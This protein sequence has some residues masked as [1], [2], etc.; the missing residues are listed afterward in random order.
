MIL[1]DHT[2]RSAI[3]S[4]RI[5]VDPIPHSDQIQPASLDL[6]LGSEFA[7][8]TEYGDLNY[9]RDEIPLVPSVRYLGHTKETIDLP[10]D[11]AAQLAGRSSIGRRGIIVHKTAGWI[12]PGFSGQ[13]TL[14]LMNL[15]DETVTLESGERVAQLVFFPLDEPSSGYDGSY[16]GQKGATEAR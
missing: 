9:E 3:G 6:R 5:G 4:E 1:S 16:Q 14:E 13:I 15:G 8:L 11:L 2:I 10:D 12:D 7:E